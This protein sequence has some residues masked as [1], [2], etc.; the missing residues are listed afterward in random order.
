MLC[1]SRNGELR[2]KLGYRTVAYS[3]TSSARTSD[4]MSSRRRSTTYVESVCLHASRLDQ[5]CVH[6][7]FIFDMRIEFR[8]SED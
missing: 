6:A 1:P 4:V 2:A 3:I 8:C 5:G 7:E